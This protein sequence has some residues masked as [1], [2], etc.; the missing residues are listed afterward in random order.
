[1]ENAMAKSHLI[2]LIVMGALLAEPAFAGDPCL[3]HNR[4]RSW[5]AVDDQTMVYS[6]RQFRD[7]TVT[8]RRP[9]RN[10]TV[11]NATLVN[12]H[13]HGLMCLAPGHSCHVSAPGRAAS[14]CVVDSVQPPA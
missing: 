7:F 3:Q 12:R 9:C 5:R 13:W 2:S 6:D 4:A 14:T 10:L 1:M 8:F 11:G